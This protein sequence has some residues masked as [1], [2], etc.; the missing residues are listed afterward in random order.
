MPKQ[1]P[2]GWSFKA[3]KAWIKR[4]KSRKRA[5]EHNQWTGENPSG[6]FALVR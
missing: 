1:L 6:E 4:Q 5:H 2:K 3:L